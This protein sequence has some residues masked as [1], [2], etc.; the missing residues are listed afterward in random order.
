MNFRFQFRQM[1]LSLD[2]AASHEDDQLGAD[3]VST[4]NTSSEV[5]SIYCINFDLNITV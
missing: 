5:R 3:E 2:Q 1:M 4:T